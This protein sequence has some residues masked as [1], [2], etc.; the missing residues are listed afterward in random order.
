VNAIKNQPGIRELD[1]R[2]DEHLIEDLL[3]QYTEQPYA[4]RNLRGLLQ[5]FV[6]SVHFIK[7]IKITE[8]KINVTISKGDAHGIKDSRS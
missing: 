3:K 7:C 4:S 5:K 2:I 6:I 8:I 1:P